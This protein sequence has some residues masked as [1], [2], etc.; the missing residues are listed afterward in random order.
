[1]PIIGQDDRFFLTDTG[2]RI[3]K[4]GLSQDKAA[5]FQNLIA[6]TPSQVLTQGQGPQGI[7]L[8]PAQPTMTPVP[9]AQA[10]MVNTIPAQANL[11]LWEQPAAYSATSPTQLNM[12]PQQQVSTGPV[13]SV[14]TQPAT[15]LDIGAVGQKYLNSINDG[16]NMQM[17]GEQ[18]IANAKARMGQ[19]LLEEQ[20]AIERRQAQLDWDLQ[21]ERDQANM[22]IAEATSKLDTLRSDYAANNKVDPDRFFKGNTGKRIMAGIAIAFGELGR[23]LTGGSQNAALNIIQSAIDN[24]IDAQKEEIAGRQTQVAQAREG[25]T[26]VR[27]LFKDRI[28]AQAAQKVMFLEQ[29]QRKFE[30]IASRYGTEE[31]KAVAQKN[32]GALE[33]K[34]AELIGGLLDRASKDVTK[35]T[36]AAKALSSAEDNLRQEREKSE[37]YKKTVARRDAVA[38][39]EAAQ[40]EKSGAGDIALIFSYMK[41]LDPGSTVMQGEYANAQNAAGI[42]ERVRAVYNKALSGQKVSDTTKAEFV[43]SA[44]SILAASEK[45]LARKDTSLRKIAKQRGLN[46]DM[47]FVN[48][49]A[50]EVD[51][52]QL[53]SFTPRGQEP[54]Q[55]TGTA[56]VM[57]GR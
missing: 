25:L 22:R 2:G 11:P 6:S 43:K 40:A 56:N 50:A 18:K 42:D 19:E 31:A 13:G 37:E 46:E 3:A 4:S 9:A 41:S 14:D 29:A 1:M 53:S 45:T 24:D 49:P 10:P 16:I 27:A 32:I 17:Q 35:S 26:D 44:R 36:E 21:Q 33:V 7:V 51:T 39:M 30:Q 23:G 47:I 52:S 38:V 8:P 20:R 55:K 12:E 28:D 57:P 54:K 15:G 5:Q 34:K 48:A